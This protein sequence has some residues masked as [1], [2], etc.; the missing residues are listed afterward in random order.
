MQGLSLMALRFSVTPPPASQV[1]P[2]GI[3]AVQ[4]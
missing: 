2:E 1:D 4:F 3:V